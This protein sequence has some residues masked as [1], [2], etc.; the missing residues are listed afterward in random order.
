MKNQRL[1]VLMPLIL[2]GVLVFAGGVHGEARLSEQRTKTDLGNRAYTSWEEFLDERRAILKPQD[3]EV[4]G[5]F[6]GSLDGKTEHA[7]ILWHKRKRMEG[8]VGY[9]EESLVELYALQ[10]R[11]GGAVEINK[12]DAIVVKAYASFEGLNGRDLNGDG[13]KEILLLV[14]GYG[15]CWGCTHI[16]LFHLSQGQLKEVSVEVSGG[17]VTKRV[18]DIDGDG[19][20]EVIGLDT[21]WEWGF[22]SARLCHGCSPSVAVVFAWENGKYVEA[23]RRFPKFY[24]GRIEELEKKLKSPRDDGSYLGDAASLLLNYIQKGEAGEGWKRFQELISP[25]RFKHPGWAKSAQEAA[26]ELKKAYGF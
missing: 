1:Y 13:L 9:V 8:Y 12:N 4:S 26:K 6:Y 10:P 24:Y 15:N 17:V 19:K 22:E 5:T 11:I 23:S 20:F 25:S 21:R 18:E 2:S 3:F 14:G 16:E 7:V